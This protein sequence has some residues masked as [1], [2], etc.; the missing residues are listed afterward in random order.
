MGFERMTPVQASAI[1]LFMAH[2]DVVTEAVTGSG[3]TLAFVLP[4]LEKLV[5]RSEPLRAREVGAIIISPT[6][7]VRAR[8]QPAHA[9]S[10]LA[11]QI[12]SV[13]TAFFDAQPS[14]STAPIPPALLLI[15]GATTLKQD[16]ARF[17]E[18]GATILVGTPG[19]LEEFL[20]GAS[21]IGKGKTSTKK[22]RVLA[23]VKTLEMLVLDEADRLLDLG[24]APTLT[25]LLGLFP[26][27]RRTGLF[28]ATMTDALTDLVRVGLR[29]PVRVV[30]KVESKRGA[31]SESRRTPATC[32]RANRNE[33]TA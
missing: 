29:N 17:L 7:S 2:K 28:S 4:L 33:L 23:S 18:T 30:V 14:T 3:K 15:G 25:R 8:V 31:K 12:H 9:R 13:V 11:T 32:V 16:Q 24:F 6:R 26:K 10:E 5:R 22:S 21:S 27:Q 19:R 20:C 1:P